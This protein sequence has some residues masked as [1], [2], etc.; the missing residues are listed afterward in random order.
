[1]IFQNFGFNQNYASIAAPPEP[2]PEGGITRLAISSSLWAY[3]DIGFSASYSSS[4]Q[5]T[6][7]DLS[8][9]NNHGAIAGTVNYN[10]AGI[11]GSVLRLGA[12]SQSNR[13]DTPSISLPT[14]GSIT[15][16]ISFYIQS[17]VYYVGSTELM[18]GRDG[19]GDYYGYYATNDTDWDSQWAPTI[20]NYAQVPI[21]QPVNSAASGSWH[22]AQFSFN[23]STNVWNWCADGVTGSYTAATSFN[24]ASLAKISWNNNPAGLPNRYL[25]SGSMMQVMAIYTGSLSTQELLDNHNSIKLRY[26]L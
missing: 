2:P 1:M 5:T 18:G 22:I 10:D 8:G 3:Y 11:S 6:V 21:P 17:A 15:M 14:G 4:G 16:V 24:N 23:D 25:N 26:G 19:Q 20:E 12:S 7:F 9:N 13:V